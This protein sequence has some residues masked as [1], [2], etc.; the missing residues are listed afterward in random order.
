M[1]QSGRISKL[2]FT[3]YHNGI[4]VDLR[5]KINNKIRLSLKLLTKSGKQKFISLNIGEYLYKVF[6]KEF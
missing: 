1:P 2:V 5:E 3:K 4:A 6:T